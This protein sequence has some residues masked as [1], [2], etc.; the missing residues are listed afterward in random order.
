MGSWDEGTRGVSV[1]PVHPELAGAEDASA[2][3]EGL[4]SKHGRV[5]LSYRIVLHVVSFMYPEAYIMHF[6]WRC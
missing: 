2:V 1:S 6:I 4:A 5:R 3:E